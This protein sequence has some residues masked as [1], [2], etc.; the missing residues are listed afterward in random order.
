MTARILL[1][2]ALLFTTSLLNAQVRKDLLE[3]QPDNSWKIYVE[4]EIPVEF[5]GVTQA[6]VEFD[7]TQQFRDKPVRD[8]NGFVLERL[9]RQEE[10]VEGRRG[11]PIANPNAQLPIDPA[12]QT[13]PPIHGFDRAVDISVNGMG[14]TGVSPADPCLD[15]GPSHVIQMI[16]GSSGG[17]F[18]IYNKNL[19]SVGAQTYL[20]NFTSS[21][22]GAGDPIVVYDALAD[23]WLMSEFSSSG[24]KL[25][26][27]ISQTADPTGAWYA[28]SYQATN[29]PD[30]PKYGVWN[31]CYVVTSN[32]NT[33]AIYA[34]PRA[35]MLAGTAGTAVRFSVSSYGSIGFQSTT[36]VT[37][38]GGTAPPVGAPAMFMRMADNG[39]GAPAD[40]L[41]MWNINYNATT[42][43][44]S[45][46]T[47]PTI[48]LTDQFD[49]ALCGYTTLNCINQPGTQTL[50]PLREV[51]MNR[52]CYRNIAG[53][54]AL[55]CSH[56]V[57]VDL[58]DRAGVRWYELH[59]T[60]GS[61]NPWGIYQQGTYSPDANDRW[62][63]SIAINNN[64]DIGLVYNISGTTGGNVYPS[65]RYTGRYK[66]DPLGQ[67]TIA[68]TTIVS[69]TASNSNNRYGDYNSLDVDPAD[70]I[71]FYGTAM[72][73]PATSWSTRIFKFSFVAVGC[74]PPTVSQNTVDN[75]GN[76]TFT[77][78]VTIGAN[79][80]SPNYDIYT[81]VNGA[82][83]T[84]NS[85][86]TPGT[87][88]VGTYA[89]GT[90]V[91]LQ[92]RH[93]A[94]ALCNQ[95]FGAVSSNGTS[96]CT[97][98]S[99][100]I[101]G[102]CI[103]STNYS[104]S[105]NLASMGNAT[106]IAIQIDPDAGGPAVPVTMQT[107]TGPGSYGP[108]GNY[109]SGSPV[110]VVLVHNLFSQCSYSENG[111]VK[112]CNM[113]GAGC[114]LFTNSTPTALADVATTTSNIVVPSQSG[115]TI[116]DLNVYVNISHTYSAD[117]R[118]SLKSPANTTVNLISTGLCT[119]N[120]NIIAEFDDT[121]VNGNVGTTCPI[122]N[123]YVIPAS[124]LSA[125]NGQLFQGTWTLSV[126]DVAAQDVGTLNSWCLVPTLS[127]PVVRVAAKAFLQGPYN[128]TQL[129]MN[130]TLR[131]IGLIPTNEPHTALGYVHV[132]GGGGETITPGTLTVSGSNAIVD[133]VILELRNSANSAQ[134][135]ATRSALIQRD[136]DVVDMDGTSAVSFAVT[137]GNYYVAV[138]HRNHL[139][140]M[141]ASTVALSSTAA[142]VNFTLPGTVT[143][144][145]AAQKQIGAIM[146]LWSGNA[147][148]DNTLRYT[149]TAND[150]D[151]ILFLI[152]GSVPTNV[153]TGY[154]QEDVNLDGVVKYTGGLND[155]DPILQN[156]GGSVPTD[157]RSQQLP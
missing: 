71:S 27:A 48:L 30:Y 156:I 15:V 33:P 103:G 56:A 90:S 141:V 86:R 139:G 52:I 131:M 63:P 80:D 54:E 57:D 95:T 66:A 32:E 94:N 72:Y 132:G 113:P 64:G 85:T 120:D 55:V 45:T 157:I 51:L 92:V 12:L 126:Q 146:A 151:P 142:T 117:L 79:G 100:T 16:N 31:N 38:D 69:G 29:F 41:E 137:A 39:W 81:N 59:R 105:V 152:G 23:R 9:E 67:M 34:L 20:D 62:M 143:Y 50:D 6:F 14:N 93:N 121:G 91:V 150:R 18:R 128:T 22:A 2:T 26:V 102:N 111:F 7:T 24:N 88:T 153:V 17:Y 136:G 35:N 148:W 53:Y 129:M 1:V 44:S 4:K 77:L 43:S 109:T 110:N 60:G 127:T 145:T 3:V 76:N 5:L 135:V 78:S 49:S 149:N 46:I 82:G 104:V 21:V 73:N 140:A 74:T 116:T 98:P 138:R 118:I 89:Y 36:P 13:A 123:L 19:V 112:N 108:F 115:A 133:W 106:S 61:A 96:C 37:F 114:G 107:V 87:Y 10:N 97:T 70:G 134:V 65:V 75:C 124:A 99:A 84:F 42:P 144:G 40:R 8:A 25:L 101:V 147:L 154:H 130:D 68:E 11:H 155:R 47:G 83:L 28:Y 58:T 119:S 122:N 125:F